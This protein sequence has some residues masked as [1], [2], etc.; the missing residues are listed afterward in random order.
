M[1][2]V[3]WLDSPCHVVSHALREMGERDGSSAL[4]S[5]DVWQVALVTR[6]P[7]TQGEIFWVE[8]K[9]KMEGF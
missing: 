8:R 3:E 7:G 2:E 5:K 6:M 1:E 4:P 9:I